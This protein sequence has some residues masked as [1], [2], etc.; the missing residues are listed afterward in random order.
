MTTY[1]EF[2]VEQDTPIQPIKLTFRKDYLVYA[3]IIWIIATVFF[4]FPKVSAL[5]KSVDWLK[6]EKEQLLQKVWP[7]YQRCVDMC[8]AEKMDY[9]WQLKTVKAKIRKA[10]LNAP[11]E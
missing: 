7:E 11:K 6:Q 10:E 3:L 8:E 4:F 1:D 5:Q 9:D 2:G